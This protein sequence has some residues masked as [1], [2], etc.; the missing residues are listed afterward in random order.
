M[1]TLAAHV[2]LRWRDAWAK[3]TDSE[4]EQLRSV[5]AWVVHSHKSSTV[6]LAEEADVH[7]HDVRNFLA[8]TGS[9]PG[10]RPGLRMLWFAAR[11]E[12]DPSPAKPEE[13]KSK[14]RALSDVAKRLAV[15]E[16]DDDYFFRHLQRLGVIDEQDCKDI[17]EKISGHYYSHRLSRNTGKIIR[18]HYEFDKFSPFNRLP[19][20]IN[21]LKYGGP[22]NRD[23]VERTAEGQIV[24]LGNAYL[25]IGFVYRGFRELGKRMRGKKVKHDGIQIN[26][27]PA[28]QMDR[29]SPSVIDGL[30]L[31][32]VYGERYEMGKMKLLR[33]DPSGNPNEFDQRQ[34]G[35]FTVDEIEKMEPDEPDLKLSELKLDVSPMLEGQPGQSDTV[36]LAACLSFL[37]TPE[38]ISLRP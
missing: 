14:I 36:L 5:I 28:V 35:E 22:T 15:F 30:F 29:K 16:P 17:C 18:S 6:R 32:Y 21:R 10:H 26:L 33:K 25:L 34:V 24:R 38:N 11:L 23:A 3:V 12:Q 7:P 19:H 37:L 27:F 4:I 13:I 20:F 2:P 31:S 1:T 9:R 8:G